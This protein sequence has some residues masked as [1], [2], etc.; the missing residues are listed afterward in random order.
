MDNLKTKHN[1]NIDIRYKY[2]NDDGDNSPDD[3]DERYELDGLLDLTVSAEDRLVEPAG[4]K[5]VCSQ[6]YDTI[7][8]LYIY[9]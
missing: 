9:I 7:Y 1:I 4:G 8:L 5:L 2:D 3:K 6:L